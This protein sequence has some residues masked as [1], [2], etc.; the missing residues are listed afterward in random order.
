MAKFDNFNGDVDIVGGGVAALTAAQILADAKDNGYPL[1]DISIYEADDVMGGRAETIIHAGRSV[2]TGCHWFHGDRENSFFRWVRSRYGM[3]WKSLMKDDLSRVKSI[4]DGSASIGNFRQV[5][6]AILQAQYAAYRAAHIGKDISLGDLAFLAGDRVAITTAIFMARNWMGMESPHDVSAFEFFGDPYGSGGYQIKGGIGDV[7]NKMV[8]TL[9]TQKVNIHTGS[10][11]Q[12]VEHVGNNVV[13]LDA[14][15]KQH[16][17]GWNIVT[18][19][20]GVLKRGDIQFDRD[21]KAKI[22]SRIEDL[23]VAR[24]TKVFVP[25][26]ESFFKERGFEANTRYNI[27]SG[28]TMVVVL[29]LTAGK[30]GI[31]IMA[32]GKLAAQLEDMTD[33]QIKRFVEDS[34][35]HV[36]SLKGWENFVDGEIYVTHWNSDPLSS[37]AYTA[38]RPGGQRVYSPRQGRVIFAGEAF[39]ADNR[40]SPST[41]AGAHISGLYAGRRVLAGL[42]KET[43]YKPPSRTR[44]LVVA[45]RLSLQKHIIH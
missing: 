27:I 12:S 30:P 31:T 33:S 11:V 36:N 24:L 13:R 34:F 26:K 39:V 20:I 9:T 7:I 45:P 18:A 1:G 40:R 8:G 14:G 44:K 41:L 22:D 19:P 2:D 3:P 5:G 23:A 6:L 38:I 29:V 42:E 25:I 16:F 35:R 32:G 15:E 17:A 4:I 37:G 21:V 10:R 28:D 43:G